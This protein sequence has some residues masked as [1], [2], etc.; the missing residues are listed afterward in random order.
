MTYSHVGTFLYFDSDGKL[1]DDLHW[2]YRFLDRVEG[3]IEDLGNLGTDGI[4]DHS[5]DKYVK[6]LQ[7]NINFN[8]F[9][10]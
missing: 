3:R 4:K 10:S 8:P 9:V 6:W 2:W 1:S 5:M 7:K